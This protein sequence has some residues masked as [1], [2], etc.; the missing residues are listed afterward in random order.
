VAQVAVCSEIRTEHTNAVWA[1][2]IKRKRKSL[3][4]FKT[5]DTYSNQYATEQ[6]TWGKYGL[7]AGSTTLDTQNKNDEVHA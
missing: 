4:N 1:K 5:D 3:L 7:N 2:R 6:V